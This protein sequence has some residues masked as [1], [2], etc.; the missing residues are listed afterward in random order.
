MNETFKKVAPIVGDAALAIIFE[1][2]KMI[3]FRGL[4]SRIEAVV[5]ENFIDKLF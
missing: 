3:A 5:P 1:T 4:K 2:A